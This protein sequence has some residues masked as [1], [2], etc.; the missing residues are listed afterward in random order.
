MCTGAL[1]MTGNEPRGQK[2]LR[3]FRILPKNAHDSESFEP[4]KL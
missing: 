2:R 1:K 4:E 3:N